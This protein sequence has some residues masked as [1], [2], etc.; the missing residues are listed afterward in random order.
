MFGEESRMPKK[1]AM[2]LLEATNLPDDNYV[3]LS[4]IPVEAYQPQEQP[5]PFAS[6]SDQNHPINS[7]NKWNI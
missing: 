3:L 5:S 6:M 2:R 4:D 7:A 1:A